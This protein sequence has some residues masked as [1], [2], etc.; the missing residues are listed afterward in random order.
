MS[1]EPIAEIIFYQFHVLRVPKVFLEPISFGNTEVRDVDGA[2]A[3]KGF[4]CVS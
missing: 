3:Q 2:F 4:I 1:F